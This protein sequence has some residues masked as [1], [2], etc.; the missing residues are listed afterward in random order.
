MQAQVRLEH[1]LLAVESEHRVHAMLELVAPAVE[2]DGSRPPLHLGLVIDRSGSMTGRKLGVTK[3]CARYLVRRLHADDELSLVAY[4]HAVDLLAPL[5]RV[6]HAKLDAAIERI[7]PRG[8][9]N[10]SGGWLK[11]TEQ[12]QGA[13][14]D[15]ARKVLL[16]T[17]GLANQGV[18][19][20]ATLVG[21]ARS[22]AEQGIGTT[23]I[24]FGQDFDEDLLTA[25]ADA[26][27]GN[28]HYAETPDEAPG[29]FA[30]EFEGLASI[31]VQNVSVE[32]RPTQ[33]VRR[34]GVLNDYPQVA[35]PGGVQ[36]QLGDAY[37]EERR[38][39]VFELH[40][41]ELARLGVA[42]AAEVVIRY[43]SVG[44]EVAAHQL[45][46]PIRVNMVSADEAA[47]AEADKEVTEQVVILKSARAE[48]EARK[49]AD[50]GDIDGAM[51]LLQSTAG[52]LR[53]FAS[54]SDQ[55]DALQEQV[56]RLGEWHKTM[57]SGQ[58]GAASSK[59][60]HFASHSTQRSRRRRGRRSPKPQGDEGGQ[61][62]RRDAP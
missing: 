34:L 61:S 19:E 56:D 54:M 4:D 9:T 12:L 60:A 20:P 37:A 28:A 21:M 29:I 46:L 33:E 40:I 50:G 2:A 36:I 39:V 7:Y 16:L 31:V 43:T 27:R 24:G 15:G 42:T 55:S 11:G 41:P 10:L 25:M 18:T 26:G 57:S 30:Q 32:I 6:D 53:G 5:A 58:W 48:E 52:E 13:N 8:S 22:M 35:V 1:E 3:E 59:A 44:E 49:K 14:G 38:G 23:T 45:M 47:A 51:F 17:D 62:P